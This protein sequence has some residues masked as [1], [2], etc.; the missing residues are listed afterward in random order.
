M[1]GHCAM[2]NFNKLSLGFGFLMVEFLGNAVCTL[3]NVGMGILENTCKTLP[4]VC[5][6]E[7]RL[8]F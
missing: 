4:Y 1:E 3:I 2:F 8:V 5:V 6:L 7:S